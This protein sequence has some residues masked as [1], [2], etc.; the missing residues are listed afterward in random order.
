M[1]VSLQ[2][3]LLWLLLSVITVVWLL[4]C[5]NIYEDTQDEVEELFDANLAQTAKVLYRLLEHEIL[6]HDNAHF[7]TQELE[8]KHRYERKIAFS[9][10]NNSGELVA[11]SSNIL[12]FP[13]EMDREG[14]HNY[15]VQPYN[16]RVFTF[17]AKHGIVQTAERYDVRNELVNDVS[18]HALKNLLFALP[19]LAILIWFSIGRGLKP[20]KKITYELTL[21]THD[22][23]QPVSTQAVPVEI[24]SVIDALNSLF[25]RVAYAFE[26]ER[27]F[28]AD[29]AHEL[30][31]PLSGLKVQ[32]QVAL[33]SEDSEVRQ[34][35][36]QKILCGV[37]H[38]SHLV[39]QLLTLARMDST[40]P[41]L[42]KTID[43]QYIAQQVLNN[44]VEKALEKNQD[45]GLMVQTE[46][47]LVQGNAEALEILLRNFVDNALRYTPESGEVTV[48]LTQTATDR[49]C[50]S[51][52][53]NGI[54]IAPDQREK[55]FER[56]YR[57]NH[58]HIQ[59]SGLGL[60]IVQRIA[61]L[62]QLRIELCDPPQGRGLVVNVYFPVKNT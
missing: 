41:L 53:D 45:L 19:L 54:G 30:R 20:L 59:G 6:D 32:A 29:A 58:Q 5:W 11:S 34:Q 7:L 33:R 62:H 40:Q 28:T 23:L 60:S 52:T 27:R 48:S 51:I 55:I 18:L 39:S 14:Y 36:L 50:L 57:G 37:D 12:L 21:R 10:R 42:I 49:L 61:E 38:A 16:W 22:Q 8:L 3:R 9:V 46:N 1:N 44:L 43:L 25:N 35:A 4:A 47:S 26:N 13:P 17:K 24:K 31:T 2:H 56:F 15:I